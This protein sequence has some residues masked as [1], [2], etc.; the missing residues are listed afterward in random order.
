MKQQMPEVPGSKQQLI[1]R[2]TKYM[3]RDE[4][5]EKY[6]E[7]VSVDSLKA[8]KL[9]QKLDYNDDPLLLAHIA[10]TY[11]DES[12]FEE[13]GTPRELLK[14]RKLKTAER[15]IVKSFKLD[16]NCL[17]VLSTMGSLRR[18]SGQNDLAIYCYE[19]IIELGIKGA[20]SDK[21]DLDK[22]FAKELIND[23]KF[24]LY[25]LHYEDNPSL[26]EKYLAMYKKGLEKGINTIYK[27]L[28]R[29]LLV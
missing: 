11:L 20:K 10:Q 7:I 17:L 14:W 2:K 27:P 23:S 24:E 5:I 19:K 12:R 18:S 6:S 25:R 28:E 3:N 21:C 15:Y 1:K 29:F 9:I 26:S 8:R 22:D 16:S 13:D 4:I